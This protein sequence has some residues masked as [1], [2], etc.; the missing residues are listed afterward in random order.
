M[1]EATPVNLP[2]HAPNTTGTAVN[3]AAHD[4][5]SFLKWVWGGLKTALAALLGV[6]A[7]IYLADVG[8]RQRPLRGF[9]RVARL[10]DILQHGK[11]SATTGKRIYEVVV[12]ETRRDAWMIHP[13]QVLGRVWLVHDPNQKI[14]PNDPQSALVAFS[15]VCPHLGCSVRY[16]AMDDRFSCPC[17]AGVFDL[18]GQVVEGPPPRPMDRL[19]VRLV[20][21]KSSSSNPPDYFVEVYYQEFVPDIPQAIPRS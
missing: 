20:P 14:E 1:S 2:D 12:R 6:P 7:L 21:D 19:Q 18:S 3:K 17:H 13:N 16:D 15:A 5:R 4:R 10:S 8:R 11:T 9:R